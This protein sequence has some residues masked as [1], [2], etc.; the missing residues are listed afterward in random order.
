M[1][2]E[3][4]SNSTAVVGQE[5]AVKEQQRKRDR[6]CPSVCQALCLSLLLD[7]IHLVD[8]HVRGVEL[9]AVVVTSSVGSVHLHILVG[10]SMPMRSMGDLYRAHCRRHKS[11]ESAKQTFQVLDALFFP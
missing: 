10:M 8:V 1:V 6:L 3:L 11:A 9:G 5:G 4:G 2:L 7:R